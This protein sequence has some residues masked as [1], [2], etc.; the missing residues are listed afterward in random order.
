MASNQ[1]DEEAL[2]KLRLVE[3]GYNSR[4]PFMSVFD[5]TYF[6]KA[7]LESEESLQYIRTARTLYEIDVGEKEINLFLVVKGF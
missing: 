2:K 4:H 1:S 3:K 7:P 5:P 6:L